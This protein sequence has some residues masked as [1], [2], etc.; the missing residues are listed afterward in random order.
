MAAS[1]MITRIRV[2]PVNAVDGTANDPDTA[3]VVPAEV[4]TF[5][6][7]SAKSMSLL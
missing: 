5:S 3:A 2:D 6:P 1:L 7:A 4:Y